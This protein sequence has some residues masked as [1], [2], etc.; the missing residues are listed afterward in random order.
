MRRWRPSKWQENP[1][2]PKPAAETAATESLIPHQSKLRLRLPL[3]QLFFR[4]AMLG[5]ASRDETRT[6]PKNERKPNAAGGLLIETK[7]SCV[8]GGNLLSSD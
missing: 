5:R 4:F 8:R 6:V 2:E 1:L 7:E 3:P